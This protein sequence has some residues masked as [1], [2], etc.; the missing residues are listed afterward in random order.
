MPR[1]YTA[2][3]HHETFRASFSLPFAS[4]SHATSGSSTPSLFLLPFRIFSSNC[5]PVLR[6][7]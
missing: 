2:S 6:R 1:V 3:R 7:V 5:L 4:N